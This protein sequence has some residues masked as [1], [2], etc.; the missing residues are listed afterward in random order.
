[1]NEWA[2]KEIERANKIRKELGCSTLKEAKKELQKR[3]MT[4]K[5]ANYDSKHKK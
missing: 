5:N 1:M 4:V 2:K 3:L